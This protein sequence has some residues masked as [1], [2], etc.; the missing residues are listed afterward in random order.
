MAFASGLVFG[1]VL[2][3]VSTS[4]QPVPY[5]EPD[6][7]TYV[8]V[9]NGPVPNPP[10]PVQIH[11]PAPADA[12][13]A[14]DGRTARQAL[15]KVE[16]SRCRNDGAPRGYGHAEVVFNPSGDISKVTVDQPTGLSEAAVRCIGYELGRTTIPAYT[17]SRVTVGT[18]F[19]VP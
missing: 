12:P 7:I 4:P 19:F 14:F 17:G 2:T 3:T 8:Y 11:E 16:L 13:P 10:V 9:N 6:N 1:S 18:T 5:R 15:A